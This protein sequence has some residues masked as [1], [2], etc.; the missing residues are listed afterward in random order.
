[1]EEKG[2]FEKDLERAKVWEMKLLKNICEANPELSTTDYLR[3]YDVRSLEEYQKKD[4]DFIVKDRDKT[5]LS[6]E[7]KI[8]FTK[9]PNFFF[10]IDRATGEGALFKTESDEVWFF[11][12]ETDSLY[13]FKTTELKEYLTKTLT[14]IKEIALKK[15][16]GEGL[17]P[18]QIDMLNWYK[19][20]TNKTNTIGLAIPIESVIKE[21]SVINDYKVSK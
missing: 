12:T 10:E 3:L 17:F 14:E 19:P 4:I 6:I 9:Y 8:D 21:L 1:M 15:S 11:F 5:L 18:A 16:K 13:R 2:Q 20:S 7:A